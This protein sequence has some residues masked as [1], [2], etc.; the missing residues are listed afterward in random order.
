M[1]KK[2]K[3]RIITIITALVM[4]FSVVMVFPDVT[5]AENTF[6]QNIATNGLN[7]EEIT[8]DNATVFTIFL[9]DAATDQT[10]PENRGDGFQS[11]WKML[12]QSQLD[13]LETTVGIRAIF[14]NQSTR[15]W[16]N[17]EMI[18]YSLI[19]A[20]GEYVDDTVDV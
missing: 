14:G 10:H 13:S 5:K 2:A 4:I 12:T 9:S 20:Q 15:Q 3:T 6:D 16:L 7:Y 18:N 17:S 11:R 1:I 8:G 19:T